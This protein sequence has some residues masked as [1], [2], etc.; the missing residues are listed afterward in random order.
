MIVAFWSNCRGR[1]VTSDLACISVLSTM[2]R[3]FGRT[4]LFENHRNYINLGNTFFNPI[5]D[6][7]VLETANYTVES[8][9]SR[10]MRS[11]ELGE[12]PSY[13]RFFS[14]TKD[15]LGK[16]LFYLSGE[17]SE[18]SDILEYRINKDCVKLLDC[19]EHYSEV[20][21]IDT[22]G[23]SLESTRKILNRADI[24]VVNLSQNDAMLSQ[25]FRNYS[26]IQKKAFY[27]LG[28]YDRESVLTKS[29]IAD[30]YNIPRDNIGVIPHNA[31]FLD[32]ISKGRLIPFL[33]K[34]YKC[35]RDDE[36]YYFMKSAKE[37]TELLN[38][39]IWL[40]GNERLK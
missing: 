27:L 31:G 9:L 22:A 26:L 32:A 33:I 11:Y 29:Q 8:N 4:I 38:R 15:F 3:P 39:Y 28:N 10:V 1:A 6:N 30:K 21:M 36:Y 5:I 18:S 13:D 20:V 17:G 12:F 14:F 7:V 25:Y 35:H 37:A 24:V 40:K 23:S 19:L 34:N 16:Q 2:S